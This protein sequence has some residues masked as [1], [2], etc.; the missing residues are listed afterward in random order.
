MKFMIL[1]GFD[2]L[3]IS[4][5]RIRSDVLEVLQVRTLRE[6][7]PRSSAPLGSR[8]A[9]NPRSVLARSRMQLAKCCEMR[10]VTPTPFVTDATLATQRMTTRLRAV[11]RQARTGKTRRPNADMNDSLGSGLS[12]ISICSTQYD[13]RM[14]F[15]K[16]APASII[17]GERS[18]ALGNTVQTAELKSVFTKLRHFAI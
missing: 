9:T 5:Q 17:C 15:T 2:F 3:M 8:A 7:V 16:C 14:L 10:V 18:A 1:H 12:S 11:L 4:A 13:L 6:P